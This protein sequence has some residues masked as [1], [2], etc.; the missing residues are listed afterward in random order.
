MNPFPHQNKRTNT[1]AVAQY[2]SS[3][4]IWISRNYGANF[5]LVANT[6]NIAFNAAASNYA[7]SLFVTAEDATPTTAFGSIYKS[8]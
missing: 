6:T 4:G 1:L 3:G 7:G 8:P 5:T 2:Q